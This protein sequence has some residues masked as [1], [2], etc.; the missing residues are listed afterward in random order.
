MN[1]V[2]SL[3]MRVDVVSET[4]TYTD[5]VASARRHTALVVAGKC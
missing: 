2:L 5:P 1:L 3:L 4:V